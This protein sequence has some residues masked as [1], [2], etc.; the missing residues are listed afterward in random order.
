MEPVKFLNIN[1]ETELHLHHINVP[2]QIPIISQ[3]TTEIFRKVKP[4]ASDPEKKENFFIEHKVSDLQ[5]MGERL[6]KAKNSSTKH[7]CIS[8][9]CLALWTVAVAAI[10]LTGIFVMPLAFFAGA[11]LFVGGIVLSALLEKVINKLRATPHTMSGEGEGYLHVVGGFSLGLMPIIRY[12]V[13]SF[14]H[15]NK[16][17][18][19][20][21][22]LSDET[23]KIYKNNKEYMEENYLQIQ[24]RMRKEIEETTQ[25]IN[26]LKSLN[27]RA[28]STIEYRENQ[29]QQLQ[30]GLLELEALREF[31]AL[32]F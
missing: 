8:L 1:P 4:F 7:K 27:S 5:T 20:I 32:N 31:Y 24:E 10:V 22:T 26:T 29:L 2:Q 12:I 18:K 11:G 3:K 28:E 30:T 25:D 13:H 17:E 9:L 15:I 6:E 16:F 21:I 23:Q 14:K 19:K